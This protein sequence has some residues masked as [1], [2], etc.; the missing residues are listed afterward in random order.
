MN[1]G[2]SGDMSCSMRSRRKKRMSRREK[3][4]LFVFGA[5]A[6]PQWAPPSFTRFLDNTRHTTVGRTP[7]DE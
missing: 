1:T 6:P 2:L 5:T 7:L 3:L 4:C